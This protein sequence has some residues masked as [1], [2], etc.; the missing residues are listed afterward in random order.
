MKIDFSAVIKELDGSD[1]FGEGKKPL[2]LGTVAIEALVNVLPDQMGQPERLSGER[3]VA[4][5]VLA[6][7]ICLAQEPLD[8][9]VDD[10]ALIAD[11]IG[12]IYGAVIVWRAW[13]LLER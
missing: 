3:K 5:A 4:N 11:R 10:V 1:M 8:L 7:R 12:A 9:K 13:A 2:T 6:E